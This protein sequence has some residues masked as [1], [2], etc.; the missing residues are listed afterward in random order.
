[1]MDCFNKPVKDMTDRDLILFNIGETRSI[2]TL[3][4]NHLHTHEVAD[5]RRWKIY[6]GLFLA[7]VAI[8][9][10]LVVAVVT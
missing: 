7:F 5:E 6:I 9:G 4:T 3:L 8:A 2:K 1:M 10:S